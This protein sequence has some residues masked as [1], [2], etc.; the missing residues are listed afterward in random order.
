[1]EFLPFIEGL[2]IRLQKPLP[3]IGA[4]AKMSSMSRISEL[5]NFIMPKNVKQSSV[6]L[7]LYPHNQTI[8]MVLM[9]RP[10]YR[11]VHSGQ[12]SLPGGKFEDGD[13]SLIFTALREAK[14]EIGIDPVAVQILG[15]LTELYIPPSNFLVTPIVGFMHYRPTFFA[16]SEEVAKIIEIRLIDLLEEANIRTKSI[17]LPLGFSAKTPCYVIDDTVIWGATAMILNEFREL[18]ESVYFG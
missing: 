3:G 13:E 11:G 15:L 8:W 6:L 1:M 4:Q 9:Q 7:L 17:K 12:V 18:S 14:E 5:M 16:N 2:E 10:I